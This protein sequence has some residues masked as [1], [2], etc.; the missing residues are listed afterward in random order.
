MYDFAVPRSSRGEW[1]RAWKPVVPGIS[2][3]FHARFIRHRYPLHTHD[4]W[5]VFTVDGGAI[6]YDLDR[7]DRGVGRGIVTLLPPHVVHDGRPA[8]SAGFRKRV[9]YIGT[10]V[11]PDRLTGRAVDNP[12]IGDPGLL[13]M[14]GQLHALLEH[15]D[16][17]LAAESSLGAIGERIRMHLGECVADR[18]KLG[19]DRNLAAQLRDVLEAHLFETMTLASAGRSLDLTTPQL[20]RVFKRTYGITP[21]QYVIACRIEAARK[22]LLSGQSVVKTA[23]DVGFHDQAHFSRHFKRHVGESPARFAGSAGRR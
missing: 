20:V 7:R 11:I 2:E 19:R 10:D 22:R 21:H 14:I 1:V 3:V 8:T 23:T 12:D 4:D 5:T 9:L 16:D 18:T 6:R 17:A 15:P 13:S